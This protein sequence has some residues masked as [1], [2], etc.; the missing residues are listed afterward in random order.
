MNSRLPAFA[1]LT[2]LL[3]L[4]HAH[5][6]ASDASYQQS[7]SPASTSLTISTSSS[8]VGLESPPT[9]TAAVAYP[10]TGQTTGNVTFTVESGSTVVATGTVGVNL[11][12]LA[13]WVPSLPTC[14]YTIHAAYSGDSNLLGSASGVINQTVLGPE[15][16]SLSASPLS[17]AQGQSAA[18][19]VSVTSINGFHGVISFTCA[20]PTSEVDCESLPGSLSVPASTG[21]TLPS[22]S[23]GDVSLNVTTF[24]T[25]V[26]HAA[27]AGAFLLS[28]LSLRRRRRRLLPASAALA[29]LL[30]GCGTPTRY[31]QHDGTP[32]GSYS[33]TVTGT[34]GQLSHSQT[35]L[36]TV[37]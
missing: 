19:P 6:Q 21:V 20:T 31:V 28:L 11:T 5:G 34:S 14:S 7:V 24:P 23:A 37:R 36:L 33:I 3:A 27:I 25:T 22:T 4:S 29:L 13:S 16:F 2:L 9:L 30:T 26:Q 35:V 17:I 12:G 32:K 18:A 15:D 1:L 10:A 8:V